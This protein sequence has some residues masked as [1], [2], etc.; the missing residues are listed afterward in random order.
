MISPS[1]EQF[2]ENL[3]HGNLV[4][5]WEEVLADY[6]TPVSV[7]RKIPTRSDYSFLFESVEGGDQVGALQLSGLRNPLMVSSAQR[8]ETSR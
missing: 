4:P 5:V 1:Y 2:L 3:K 8:A 6:D 7:F